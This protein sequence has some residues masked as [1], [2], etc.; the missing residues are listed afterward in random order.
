MRARELMSTPVVTVYPET[1]LKEVAEIMAAHQISGV[2]VVDRDGRLLG[3]VS[4]SDFIA[5]METPRR[6]GFPRRLLQG[7]MAP[8]RLSG[9]TASDLMTAPVVTAGPEARMRDLVHLMTAH[10][11]N[12]LPIVDEGRVVGLV[13]RADI[14]RV[15]ARSDAAITEEV[16]WRLVHEFWIDTE[17]VD[18]TTREGVVTIAGSL[19]TRRDAGAGHALRRQHR[20]SRGRRRGGPSLPDR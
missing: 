6:R 13:T 5:R 11:V 4:E 17:T 7:A 3:I 1:P 16:L 15:L 9:R 19:D 20:W 12:R 8:S 14:L 2:P 18:V 10:D